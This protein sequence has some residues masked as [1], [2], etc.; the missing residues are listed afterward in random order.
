MLRNYLKI[1]IR[2]LLKNK[3][4]SVIN[5]SGLAI[6]MAAVMLI[7]IWVK[8]EVTYDTFHE[9][10]DQIWQLWNKGEWSGSLKCWPNTPKIAAKVLRSDFPEIEKVS[11]FNWAITTLLRWNDKKINARGNCVDPEFLDIF[12]FPLV[13]GNTTTAFKDLHS[14]VITERLAK[15]IF[16]DEDPIGKVLRR[17]NEADFTVTGVLKD[18]PPNTRF[19]FDYLLPWSYLISQE[20]DEDQW[21]NN[22]VMTYALLRP[23]A[24]MASVQARVALLRK[25]YQKNYDGIDLFLYPLK[26]WHLYSQFENGVESGGRIVLVRL[27]LVISGF[28]LLIACINFMNLS[29]ARSER[30]AREVG[31]RKTVGAVR[32]MLVRQFLGESV[33]L[34]FF[35]YV[36]ALL[37]VQLFMPAFNELVGKKLVI[38]YGSALFW[39]ASLGF[40]LLTGLLAGAYPAFFLS[41][42]RPV[43]VLKG[44]FRRSKTLVAPRKI[45]VVVQF[46]FAIVLIICTVIVKQQINYVQERD[47]GYEKKD[48]GYYFIRNGLETHFTALRAELL[49]SGLVRGVCKTSSPITEGW[50]DTWGFEWRGKDPNDKTDFDLF[51]A[52]G[53]FVTTM[54][55]KLV[56]G[57]DFN[58]ARFPADSNAILI[59]ESAQKTMQFKQPIGEIVRDGD[60]R[61]HIIGVF[62]DFIIN[63]PYHPAKPMIV[64]GPKGWFN[65]VHVRLKPGITHEEVKRVD[66]LF[67]RYNPEFDYT[68][69]FVDQDYMTKFIDEQRIGRIA[70]VFAGLTIFISCLG[71]FGLATY[72]AESR[73]KEIGIRKVL[74]ASVANITA[75][76]ASN[77]VK[78]VLVAIVIASPVAWWFMNRYLQDF[79]YH[80]SMTWWVFFASGLGAVLLALVTVSFQ[81]VRAGLANPVKNLRTE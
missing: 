27:F 7:L 58:L 33:V 60:E 55:V 14:I 76:L 44:T 12:S 11:R 43:A 57:R 42:F 69:T 50:S 47:S 59:N 15:K 49:A 26:R 64:L 28:I 36:V 23:D 22:S 31:I 70:S 51:S 10:K 20:G 66:A 29:T 35:S 48:L 38:G 73:I 30:R 32:P 39:L 45:L 52:D 18:L 74:G 13:K 75:M 6:G 62:K 25:K 19:S 78:L 53:D 9:K 4:F 8:N 1:A 24:N 67:T 17:E 16:G 65:V 21:G 40:I 61:R 80:V 37:L 72:M 5:I 68:I 81:S 34:V 46:S 56:Q 77:F 63:S 71:L 79:P 54:G 2:Q 41:S 3:A